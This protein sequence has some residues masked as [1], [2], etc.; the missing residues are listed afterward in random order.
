MALQGCV[1]PLTLQW[2]RAGVVV[3]CVHAQA[4]GRE[5]HEHGGGEVWEAHVRTHAYTHVL[6]HALTHTSQEFQLN[7]LLMGLPYMH[8]VLLVVLLTLQE[9]SPSP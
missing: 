4:C 1:Q 3:L 5:G 7:A 9:D 8:N 6:L 2:E